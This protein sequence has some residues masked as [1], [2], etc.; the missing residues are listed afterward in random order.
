MLLEGADDDAETSLLRA[1][2]LGSSGADHGKVKNAGAGR[3]GCAQYLFF[4]SS[5]ARGTQIFG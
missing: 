1:A 2:R 5:H 4:F 3:V